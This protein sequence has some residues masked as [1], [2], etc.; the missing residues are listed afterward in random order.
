MYVEFTSR[1]MREL[2]Q[3]T[4]DMSRVMHLK[5]LKFKMC[6]IHFTYYIVLNGLKRKR[7]KTATVNK[8]IFKNV[9]LFN[10]FPLYTTWFSSAEF[11]VQKK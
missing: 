11:F 4:R 3:N 1:S 9:S 5:Q 7:R 8:S 2:I 6:A 10:H